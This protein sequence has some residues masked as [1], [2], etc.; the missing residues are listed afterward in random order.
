MLHVLE[1]V[2]YGGPSDKLVERLW[3]AVTEPRFKL[4]HSGHS[5]G[6]DSGIR[7]AGRFRPRNGHTSK[8]LRSL[9]YNE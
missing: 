1:Y 7:C 9:G 5:R 3:D 4:D 2:L 8:A 6:N